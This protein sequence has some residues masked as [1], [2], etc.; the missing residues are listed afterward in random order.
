[1]KTISKGFFRVKINKC[2]SFVFHVQWHANDAGDDGGVTDGDEG[3]VETA[4]IDQ[5]RPEE[6]AGTG[7]P[8][9]IAAKRQFEKT[10]ATS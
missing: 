1:M 10:S 4:G 6:L 8:D 3:T 2:N 7:T 9:T 5:G